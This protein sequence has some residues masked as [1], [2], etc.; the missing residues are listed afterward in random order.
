MLAHT[1]EQAA[2][3]GAAV[4]DLLWGDERYKDRFATGQREGRTVLLVRPTR[5]RAAAVATVAR[6]RDAALRLPPG[7]QDRL[8]SLVSRMR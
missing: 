1:I 4:Y 6:A 7:V 8:R 5:P 3:E 2:E